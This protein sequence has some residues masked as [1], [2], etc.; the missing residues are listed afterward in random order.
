MNLR[1]SARIVALGA[2]SLILILSGLFL[3]SHEQKSRIENQIERL[4]ILRSD[5][6]QLR[7]AISDYVLYREVRA[8]LQVE[9]KLS[10]LRIRLDA[11]MQWI[12]DHA[13]LEESIGLLWENVQRRLAECETL[14]V[15]LIRQEA[16]LTPIFQE[17][18]QRTADLLLLSSQSLVLS[19][20]QLHRMAVRELGKASDHEERMLWILLTGLAGLGISLFVLLRNRILVPLKQLYEAAVLVAQGQWDHR[21]HSPR[22]DEFGELAHAF[23]HMLD[24]LQETTVSRDRLEAEIVE[25][26]QLEVE[27]RRF[28]MTDPLTG[29]F[30][31]RYLLQALETEISRAQRYTRPLSVIMFDIDH[32]KRINDTFGHEHGDAVL[33]GLATLVRQRLRHTDVFT[34]WGGEEFMILA[35]ETTLSQALALAGTLRMALHQ[36][37][38]PTVGTVT[39][40]FGVAEYRTDETVDQWLKRVDDLAYE[41]K[42][43][44]RD[45]ISH[46]RA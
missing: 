41:A 19:L 1:Y 43:N 20:S 44:G 45:Q 12:A 23:D 14:F 25:R 46:R 4:E 26:Q 17:R 21:L 18:N 8:R 40:S 10:D 42:R 28:A 32:F 24:R 9:A 29:A 39:A 35:P 34:R 11:Q 2:I 16:D 27:L 30:N 15:A 22:Q 37:P 6:I 38:F 3:Y 13:I 5:A 33:K 7:P 31:R 36:S